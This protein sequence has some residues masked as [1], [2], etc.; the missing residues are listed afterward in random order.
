[1]AGIFAVFM[2]IWGGFE[3]VST[4]AISGKSAGKE[5]IEGALWGLGLALGS[6]LIL[7]TINPELLKFSG[8]PEPIKVEELAKRVKY[9]DPYLANNQKLDA[10]RTELDECNRKAESLRSLDSD[11]ADAARLKCKVDAAKNS[12]LSK[13]EALGIKDFF[14]K[15]TTREEDARTRKAIFDG[16]KGSITQYYD[17]AISDLEKEGAA[18]EASKDVEAFKK[19]VARTALLRAQK[20]I[21]L[22]KIDQEYDTQRAF[23]EISLFGSK[24]A[25]K[26]KDAVDTIKR[27]INERSVTAYNRYKKDYPTEAET[28]RVDRVEKIKKIE[29]AYKEALDRLN[30]SINTASG[31]TIGG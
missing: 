3:Y 21:D 25:S 4:D 1:L 7:N 19:I 26:I 23:D 31:P 14:G 20:Y 8:G 2:I 12:V 28:I 11:A 22:A 13:S 30:N 17:K 16:G 29:S 10:V 6:Y 15:N 9:T 24:G 18:A 5:K 27:T